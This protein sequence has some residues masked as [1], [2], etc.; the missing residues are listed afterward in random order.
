M[1]E[2]LHKPLT[3][4]EVA[5][6]VGTN[7]NKLNQ[8]LQQ[9]YGQSFFQMLTELRMERAKLLLENSKELTITEISGRIG[10][11]NPAAFTRAFRGHF[12]ITPS[13]FREK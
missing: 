3:L 5:A 8:G 13:E 11:A 1:L 2:H 7:R 10:Y 9:A 6:E 4:T 12:S